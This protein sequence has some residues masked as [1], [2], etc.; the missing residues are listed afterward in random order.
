MSLITQIAALATR[1]AAEIKLLR[2]EIPPDLPTY[3]AGTPTE[4]TL[5]YDFETGYGWGLPQTPVLTMDVG[6]G[7]PQWS[8]GL[9][10]AYL[11]TTYDLLV[12]G[13]TVGLGG[14]ANPTNMALG[15]GALASNVTGA[16][17]CAVGSSALEK[18]TGGSYNCAVGYAALAAL[19][20]AS[21]ENTA[22]GTLAGGVLAGGNYNTFV[23]YFAG[24]ALPSGSSNTFIGRFA[25]SAV[26]S[27]GSNTIIGRV[28]GQATMSNTIIIAAGVAERV[29]CDAS[30]NWG[31][32]TAAP[33]VKMDIE[34]D[35]L[36][37]RTASTPTSATAAG[38]AGTIKWDADYVYV[39]VAPNTW[40]R[41]ALAP[42]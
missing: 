5:T 25:G 36:R 29:R 34:G 37:L 22:V 28:D 17:L 40:K 38:A 30:G 39:C 26:T 9:N 42:W 31:F 2:T 4:P 6:S 19:T 11:G 32:G 7:A 12:A 41:A 10:L 1:V 8:P 20:G 18:N 35:A 15:A 13:M 16:G 27:G 33:T 14:G 3:V 24:G 21:K 23:G